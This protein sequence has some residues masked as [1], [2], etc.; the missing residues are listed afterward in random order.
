MFK[1]LLLLVIVITLLNPVSA[2]YSLNWKN[3]QVVTPGNDVTRSA[4]YNRAT[5]HV[6]V[7]YPQIWY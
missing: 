7:S 4:V 5:D 6:L 2:Q 3:D 1:L